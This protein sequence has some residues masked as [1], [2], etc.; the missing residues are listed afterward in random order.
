MKRSLITDF[1]NKNIA[2]KEDSKE[3]KKI[4]VRYKETLAK[5][6]FVK[7]NKLSIHEVKNDK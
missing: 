1:P 7:H 6:P 2:A 3:E 5:S 4:E